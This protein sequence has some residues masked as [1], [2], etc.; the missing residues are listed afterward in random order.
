[1]SSKE[2]SIKDEARPGRPVEVTM[3]E[4]IE[5]IHC[6]VIEDHRIKMR[7]IAEIVDILVDRVHNILHKELEIK[8]ILFPRNKKALCSM[9]AAIAAYRTKTH[10]K[11]HFAAVFVNA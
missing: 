8:N 4:I 7:D 5:K 11:R 2:A 10:A 1:M 9:S 6:I 3:A